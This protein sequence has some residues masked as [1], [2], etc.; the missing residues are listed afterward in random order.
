MS[1][2]NFVRYLSE[3]INN[4]NSKKKKNIEREGRIKNNTIQRGLKVVAFPLDMKY[5]FQRVVNVFLD[6]S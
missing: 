6:L 3:N 4:E 2:Q 1:C 5:D